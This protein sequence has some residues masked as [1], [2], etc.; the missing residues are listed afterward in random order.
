LQTSFIRSIV[1]GTSLLAM[2]VVSA[3]PA[4]AV[5][6]AAGPT[7]APAA[8]R[9]A[10]AELDR[11]VRESP[12]GS[13]RGVRIRMYGQAVRPSERA[14]PAAWC[15]YFVSW[16]ARRA[17]QPIGPRGI[18]FSSVARLRAWAI[19]SGHW[20][21]RA[22]PG[23]LVVFADHVGVVSTVRGRSLT[24]I[25]GNWSDRVTRVAHRESEAD[26][27]VVLP[28]P[29]LRLQVI[30]YGGGDPPTAGLAVGNELGAG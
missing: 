7:A 27:Y 30:G 10:Q 21:H 28:P 9:I 19:R 1:A 11:G 12:L 6:R 17:G 5:A 2:L 4:S 20:T 24:S 3:F 26:G 8:A 13:N 23:E 25:E 29:A 15:G 18:G 22:A 14:Y 16:V